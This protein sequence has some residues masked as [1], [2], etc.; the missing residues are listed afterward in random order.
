MCL[1]VCVCECVCLSMYK[2]ECVCVRCIPVA[3]D[4]CDSWTLC[5]SIMWV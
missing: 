5:V 1:C 4:G 3:V 2:C